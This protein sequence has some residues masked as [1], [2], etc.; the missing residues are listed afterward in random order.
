MVRA[1]RLCLIS[2]PTTVASTTAHYPQVPPLGVAY[3]AA[4]VRHA[5]HE[6]NVVDGLGEALEAYHPFLRGQFL[7]GLSI[8]QVVDRVDPSADLIG[9]SVMFSKQ[10]PVARRIVAALREAFPDTPI[11]VGG[12]H[13][14]AAMEHVFESSPADYVVLGEG[15]DTLCELLDALALSRQPDVR[16]IDGLGYRQS[17]R[18]YATEDGGLH[19]PILGERTSA[20]VVRNAPRQRRR[21]LDALAWPAW[22]LIPLRRYIDAKRFQDCSERRVMVLMGTRGC[23][24]ECKFCSNPQMW[25]TSFFTRDP[26]D[27]VDEMEHYVRE[28]DVSEFQFQDLTFVVN[29][30]WVI[31]VAD[32]I[33]ARNLGIIWKLPGGTRSEAFDAELM[34]KLSASG[35]R[36]LCF[37]PESGSPR[38]LEAMK[39][40]ADPQHFIELGRIVRRDRV[41]VDITA[42]IIIGSPDER[43]V[44][45]L[46]T[47]WFIVRLAL[48]GY[49]G[50]MCSRFTCY[51][52]SAYHEEYLKQGLIEYDDNYF[53]D[54]DLSLANLRHGRSWHPKWGARRLQFFVMF[55]Y[56]LFF[57]VYYLSRPMRVWRS[58][59]A[60][61]RNKP[62][63]RVELV[64]AHG[65]GERLSRL[66]KFRRRR[67]MAPAS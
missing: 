63:S 7:N 39:K 57:S 32:E 24:Y 55:G 45:L 53:L 30:R 47:Y 44:D 35:C 43:F 11:V 29:R 58:V 41:D 64:V 66:W 4:A 19:L 38:V 12:E 21:A 51:P 36:S 16:R 27:L 42:F 33:I 54:L 46:Q 5:G 6:V 28:Y 10:W 59:R 23:P 60:V 48:C 50:I 22:D 67:R 15:E 65:L 31:R 1:M 9:V 40:K 13:P 56:V 18:A 52:G 34:A 26:E 3:L 8:E 49:D 37:A 14:T 17:G 2:P 20:A 62:T 25:T 61:L